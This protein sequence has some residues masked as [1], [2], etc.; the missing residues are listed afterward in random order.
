[1]RSSPTR[2]NSGSVATPL[3][4]ATLQLVPP[5]IVQACLD[6]GKIMFR[7]RDMGSAGTIGGGAESMTTSES[8]I[9]SVLMTIAD[10]RATGTSR[11]VIF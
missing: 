6:I 9:R 4:A 3:T 7:N 1:M 2:R 8:E 11:G 5:L 10:Y